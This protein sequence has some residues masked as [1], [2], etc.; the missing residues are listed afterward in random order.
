MAFIVLRSCHHP[1]VHPKRPAP[2]P[3]RKYWA[4]ERGL[5]FLNHGSFGACPKPVLAIQSE[6]RKEMEASPVQFLWR[7]Y[8]ARLQPA[9]A[10]LATFVGAGQRD[11]VFV[12]NATTAVNAVVRSWKLRC[13]DEILTTNLDYNACRN[14]LA[15]VA[16][17]AGAKVV[18]ARIPFPISKAD[19]AVEAILSCITPRTRYAMIDHVTSG[20]ALVLPISKIVSEL[21]TRGIDTLVDGA[22]APGMLA[23]NLRKLRAAWYC[24][25]LHKWVCAPKGSAFLWAREDRQDSLQPAVISHGNN[26]PRPGFT[27]FQDRFDWAGSFDPSPWFCVPDAIQ[28]MGKL[29]P[30]GWGELR[31]KNRELALEARSLLCKALGVKAPCPGGMIGSMATIP[32]PARFQG[33][34]FTSKLAPEQERLFDEC[35]IEVPFVT[36]NG[37]RC[38]RVSAQLYNTPGEY[39]YLAECIRLLPGK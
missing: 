22:H 5:V 14:V 10:A 17:A 37:L 29:L 2:S 36:I 27:P 31:R 32:L 8:E 25:N 24:G 19:D 13:A 1:S 33:V 11:L 35:R 7:H 28:W 26:C 38:F 39:A 9:R 15:E 20:S 18:V 23:L 4:L 30:G 21:E 6:L 34:R 16:K 12:T 3:L